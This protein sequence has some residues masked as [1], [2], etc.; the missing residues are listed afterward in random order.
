MPQTQPELR[1]PSSALF[2]KANRE[3]Q[4]QTMLV[5]WHYEG[6]SKLPEHYVIKTEPHRS[7]HDTNN[8]II[9]WILLKLI[10]HLMTHRSVLHSNYTR[11]VNYTLKIV[12]YSQ[13][14]GFQGLSRAVWKVRRGTSVTVFLLSLREWGSSGLRSSAWRPASLSSWPHY[15][16]ICPNLSSDSTNAK[17]GF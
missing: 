3:V 9:V 6:A 8:I 13:I 11:T 14:R 10:L 16:G 15:L 12:S 1:S 4:L 2:P 7:D 5:L 17:P